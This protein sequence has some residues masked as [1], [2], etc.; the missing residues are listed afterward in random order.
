MTFICFAAHG[1]QTPE[2]RAKI[3]MWQDADARQTS[4]KSLAGAKSKREKG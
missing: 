4:S 2:V 3:N 1:M